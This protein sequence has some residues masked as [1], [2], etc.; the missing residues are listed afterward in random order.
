MHT[1]GIVAKSKERILQIIEFYK[2][3]VLQRIESHKYVPL[4]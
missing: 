4:D 1:L 2:E 3:R